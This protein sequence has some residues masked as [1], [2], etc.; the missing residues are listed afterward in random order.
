MD[1]LTTCGSCLSAP[2]LMSDP[3][4]GTSSVQTRSGPANPTSVLNGCCGPDAGVQRSW[5]SACSRLLNVFDRL[6]RLLP[7]YLCCPPSH[8]H[9]DK[10]PHWLAGMWYKCRH[11]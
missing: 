7:P 9:V 2:S 8:M 6:D 3:K 10:A 5:T 1:N 11:G 4:Q